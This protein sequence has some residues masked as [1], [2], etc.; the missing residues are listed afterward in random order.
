MV[1]KDT[2]DTNKPEGMQYAMPSQKLLELAYANSVAWAGKN[3]YKQ[4]DEVTAAAAQIKERQREQE[5]QTLAARKHSEIENIKARLASTTDVEARRELLD[6]IEQ[7][8]TA[9]SLPALNSILG[10]ISSSLAIVLAKSGDDQEPDIGA[11]HSDLYA[12]DAVYR[13]AVD[14]TLKKSREE[15][16]TFDKAQ[17]KLDAVAAEKG[18]TNPQL[19]KDRAKVEA[20]IKE[21][22]ND[23]TKGLKLLQKKAERLKIIEEQNKDRIHQANEKGD[24][25]SKDL[26][27]HHNPV[28]EAQRKLQRENLEYLKTKLLEAVEHDLKS[29]AYAKLDSET[30][31]KDL[32]VL[33]QRL[34]KKY[35]I[36]GK[37]ND[38]I[39]EVIQQLTYE[40]ASKEAKNEK[41]LQTA[42][43]VET[44]SNKQIESMLAAGPVDKLNVLPQVQTVSVA[45]NVSPSSPP[46]GSTPTPKK[47]TL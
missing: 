33:S 46:P 34:D 12:K 7:I 45:E 9:D 19:D 44:A 14:E 39:S 25:T 37:S 38:E 21:L 40:V 24:T 41:Q 28:I 10:G 35:D 17:A 31:K 2:G 6:L 36:S 3:D 20:E 26:F 47:L 5:K 15:S 13:K 18:Y 8:S 11:M 22:E 27:E 29:R 1:K 23:P 32:S 16:D 4:S 42:A 43:T 30:I